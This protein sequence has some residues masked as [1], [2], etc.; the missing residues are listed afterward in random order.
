MRRIGRRASDPS[1]PITVLKACDAAIPAI[2]RMV[3]PEFAA[4]RGSAE[5]TR[6]WPVPVICTVAP[7]RSRRAPSAWMHASVAAQSAPP[8]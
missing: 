2:K 8:E 5:G 6:L 1:P 3:V 7:A 4:Y